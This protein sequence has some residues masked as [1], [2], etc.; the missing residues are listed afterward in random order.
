MFQVKTKTVNTIYKP[1]GYIISKDKFNEDM[2]SGLLE[3]TMKSSKNAAQG[4]LNTRLRII[5]R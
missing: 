1:E 5:E 3:E 2:K 4:K